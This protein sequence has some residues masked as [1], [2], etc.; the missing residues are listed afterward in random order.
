MLEM[1]QAP[2]PNPTEHVTFPKLEICRILKIRSCRI[3]N[4][5]F[6]PT[7]LFLIDGVICCCALFVTV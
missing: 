7:Q 2:I 6:G 5:S 4:F 1:R 3:L